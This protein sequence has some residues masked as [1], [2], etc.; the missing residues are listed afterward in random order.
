[1][2]IFV[3]STPLEVQRMTGLMFLREVKEDR[4]IEDGADQQAPLAI[5]LGTP[6]S[7]GAKGSNSLRA[8]NLLIPAA[9]HAR[10]EAAAREAA[11]AACARGL[12]QPEERDA[13][14]S[15]R[16]GLAE[17][18]PCYLYPSSLAVA[19]SMSLSL[20]LMVWQWF[21]SAFRSPA[22]PLAFLS[23]D[24][25]APARCHRSSSP[26]SWSARRK[27]KAR[28]TGRLRAGG[29]RAAE[30]AE[31]VIRSRDSETSGVSDRQG[32]AEGGAFAL[33]QGGTAGDSRRRARSQRTQ[34]GE[35]REVECA[36]CHLVVTMVLLTP[37]LSTA[38]SRFSKR[39]FADFQFLAASI[40]SWPRWFHALDRSA[41]PWRHFNVFGAAGLFRADHEPR[42]FETSREARRLT[43]HRP[44][45]RRDGP[46]A[47]RWLWPSNGPPGC[48]LLLRQQCCEPSQL[49]LHQRLRV[50][51][52][53]SSR[54]G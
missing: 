12:G 52:S 20:L 27:A 17:L 34:G 39:T 14:P 25:P 29:L 5:N 22:R 37:R 15:G 47:L 35:L 43:G 4:A 54:H 8:H 11:A 44:R 13:E 10:K 28:D 40:F 16:G 36:R 33:W 53:R 23:P 30:G 32:G 42:A 31:E 9:W 38:L 26:I 6:A 3:G 18:L 46:A 1:M 7:A 19:Y 51:A 2:N 41:S 24:R 50:V 48:K 49:W 21:L 45:G